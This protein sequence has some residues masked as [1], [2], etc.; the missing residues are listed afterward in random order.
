MGHRR[1]TA[2]SSKAFPIQFVK[3]F[4]SWID[5]AYHYSTNCLALNL[6]ADTQSTIY[7]I[8]LWDLGNAF[9]YLLANYMGLKEPSEI[10]Y[11]HLRSSLLVG[12]AKSSPLRRV[13]ADRTMESCAFAPPF[14]FEQ[15]AVPL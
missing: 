8:H 11:K 2:R 6:L 14:I 9:N 15:K 4:L 13:L 1:V 3:T 12:L 7:K 5:C 10:P